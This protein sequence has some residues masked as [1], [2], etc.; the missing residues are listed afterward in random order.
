MDLT[1]S[2]IVILGVIIL[3]SISHLGGVNELSSLLSSLLPDALETEVTRCFTLLLWW[4][5]F[6]ITKSRYSMCW[7]EFQK[8]LFQQAKKCVFINI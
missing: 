6:C 2:L 3:S 4:Y 1:A 8:Q 5:N 7:I